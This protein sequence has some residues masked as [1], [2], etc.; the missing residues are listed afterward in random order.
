MEASPTSQ[1]SQRSRPNY[2]HP[3]LLEDDPSRITEAA[4]GS[5][6]SINGG[7]TPS[8]YDPEA[9]YP[10]TENPYAYGHSPDDNTR[11]ESGTHRIGTQPSSP[12]ATHSP[13]QYNP[14]QQRQQHSPASNSSNAS[15]QSGPINMRGSLHEYYQGVIP[16]LG[17]PPLAQVSC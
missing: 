13:G 5:P 6:S 10:H 1:Q 15:Q 3:I 16:F 11:P 9:P 2:R 8:D 4:L 12:T 7:S 14:T 17:A